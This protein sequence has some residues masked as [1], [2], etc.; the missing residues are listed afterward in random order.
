[1]VIVRV[2]MQ[3]VRTRADAEEA[4]RLVNFSKTVPAAHRQQLLAMADEHGI[5]PAFQ[6]FLGL[7]PDVLGVD[8]Q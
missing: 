8:E 2:L 5:E 4:A 7:Y 6:H 3:A 1:M